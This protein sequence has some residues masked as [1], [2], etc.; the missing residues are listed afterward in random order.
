[1]DALLSVDQDKWR[2]EMAAVGE[3]MDSFGDR[4]PQRLREEHA[5]IVA[6]LGKG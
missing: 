6:T 4:V 5:R 3:Y 2:A 1:M